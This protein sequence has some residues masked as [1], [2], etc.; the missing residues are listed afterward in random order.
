MAE[1]AGLALGG[2]TLVTLFQ[3]CVEIFDYVEAGRNMT[4]DVDLGITKMYFLR[5]RLRQWGQILSINQPGFEMEALKHRWPEDSE[6]IM[7]GLGQITDVLGETRRISDRY[8]LGKP[9]IS[10]LEECADM[11]GNESLR[12][13]NGAPVWM[14]GYAIKSSPIPS[15]QRGAQQDRFRKLSHLRKRVQWAVQ[16]KRRFESLLGDLDCL[17]GSLEELSAGIR[18]TGSHLPPLLRRAILQLTH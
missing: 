17:I 15:L 6:I 10:P 13:A 18:E 1:V 12:V 9:A 11:T 7:H 16:D 2:V 5:I 3:S 14:R 8:R 4:S